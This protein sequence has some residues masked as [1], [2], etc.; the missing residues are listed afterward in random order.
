VYTSVQS[1]KG[2]FVNYKFINSHVQMCENV[3]KMSNFRR[4]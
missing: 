3:L 2:I 4:L 1:N